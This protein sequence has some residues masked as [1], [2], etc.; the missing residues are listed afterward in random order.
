MSSN[1]TGTIEYLPAG[2]FKHGGETVMDILFKLINRVWNEWT[3]PIEWG[4]MKI[5]PLFKKADASK[6]KNYWGISLICLV[7]M[8]YENILREE[9]KTSYR[10]NFK[11][12]KGTEKIQIQQIF[13]LQLKLFRKGHGSLLSHCIIDL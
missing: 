12:N 6:Y 7:A 1:K 11:I 5:M 8:F 10:F 4:K 3:I 2:L 9:H 13:Y